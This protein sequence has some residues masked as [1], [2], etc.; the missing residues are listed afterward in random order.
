MFPTN[1]QKELD[2]E[3]IRDYGRNFTLESTLTILLLHRILISILIYSY[4]KNIKWVLINGFEK[5]YDKMETMAK[6][7]YADDYETVVTVDEK[8]NEKKEAIY[9]GSF[10]EFALDEAGIVQFRRTAILLCIV[11]VI[12][13]FI[14]GF[15]GNQGMYQFYIALPYV[16]AFFPLLYLTVSVMRLPKEKR[17]YRREE[18]GLSFERIKP[19]SIV[20][21]IFLGVELLS[22]VIFLVFV[23]TGDKNVLE[24]LFLS[25]EALTATTVFFLISLWRQIHVQTCSE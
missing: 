3:S 19:T 23:S 16:F 7:K 18:I 21:M 5:L 24:Y 10:F 9:H 14:S 15:V 13:H 8:G 25:L 17:K 2:T 6:K 20:L 12:I 11:I 22:E 1:V 4:N